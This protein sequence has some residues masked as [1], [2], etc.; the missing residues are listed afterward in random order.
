MEA[1]RTMK[2]LALILKL[3]ALA[4]NDKAGSFSAHLVLNQFQIDDDGYVC[5]TRPMGLHGFLD[6]VDELKSE[7]DCLANDA[8]LWLAGSIASRRAKFAVIS[9]CVGG[10]G[11]RREGEDSSISSTPSPMRRQADIIPLPPRGG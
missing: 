1:T 6:A 11:E 4:S 10:P 5:V 3:D 9:N 7:L 8:I 2:N